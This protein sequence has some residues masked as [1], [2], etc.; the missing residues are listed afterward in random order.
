MPEKVPNKE[1]EEKNT[2][3]EVLPVTPAIPKPQPVELE[4]ARAMRCSEKE[5]MNDRRASRPLPGTEL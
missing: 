3:T 1:I 2:R 5:P 4:F